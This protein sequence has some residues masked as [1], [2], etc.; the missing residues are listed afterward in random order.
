MNTLTKDE[1]CLLKTNRGTRTGWLKIPMKLSNTTIDRNEHQGQAQASLQIRASTK[2]EQQRD[3]K[4][5]I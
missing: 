2:L 3:F 5:F 4:K 1:N